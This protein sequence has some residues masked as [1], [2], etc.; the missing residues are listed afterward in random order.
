M[1]CLL[2]GA[3]DDLWMCLICGYVGCGRYA[4]QH[5]LEHYKETSHTFSIEL[6]TQRVWDY[7]GDNYVHRLVANK[8]DGKLVELPE[9]GGMRGHASH[10][11]DEKLEVRAARAMQRRGRNNGAEDAVGAVVKEEGDGVGKGREGDRF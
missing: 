4:G 6:V 5:A 3:A 11:H 9:G 1:T 7:S 2:C 10:E 8:V